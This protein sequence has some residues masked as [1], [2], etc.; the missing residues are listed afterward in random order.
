MKK[1]EAA[2]TAEIR[3]SESGGLPE[4]LANRETATVSSYGDDEDE[5]ADETASPDWQSA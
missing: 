5:A 2:A 3:L 4:V 1:D